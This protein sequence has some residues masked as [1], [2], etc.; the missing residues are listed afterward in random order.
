VI[1]LPWS[2]DEAQVSIA[3]HNNDL[4]YTLSPQTSVIQSHISSVAGRYKG[5]ITGIINC[6]FRTWSTFW[7]VFSADVRC[8]FWLIILSW[9]SLPG[10]PSV[11]RLQVSKYIWSYSR[12]R[13]LSSEILN[14]DGS[15]RASVFSRLLGE[16]RAYFLARIRRKNLDVHISYAVV[17]H[18]CLPSCTHCW[19]HG[20][21]REVTALYDLSL[22]SSL[23]G[24]ISMTIIWILPQVQRFKLL[25]RSWKGSTLRQI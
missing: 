16:V 22:Y 19:C 18:H 23:I 17:H 25:W 21:V 5:K 15:L 24:F 3:T 14:E 20:E 10:R 12:H 1:A 4:I 7:L 6:L 8:L 11:D 9:F 2:V 13:R